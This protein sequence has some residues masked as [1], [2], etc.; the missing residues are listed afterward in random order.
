VKQVS[1]LMQSAFNLY[2]VYSSYKGKLLP[3]RSV[4]SQDSFAIGTDNAMDCIRLF[5]RLFS[6]V[7]ALIGHAQDARS[8]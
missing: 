5:L 2:S 7:G 8:E 4:S 6:M 1:N 3:F